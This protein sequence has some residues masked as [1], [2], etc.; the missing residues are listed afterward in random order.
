[1]NTGFCFL[2]CPEDLYSPASFCSDPDGVDIVLFR[3]LLREKAF[4]HMFFQKIDTARI[5]AFLSQKAV[6]II[7]LSHCGALLYIA[8]SPQPL[9]H[10][11]VRRGRDVGQFLNTVFICLLRSED[12]FRQTRIIRYFR[13]VGDPGGGFLGC[14]KRSVSLLAQ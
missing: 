3:G 1:M 2:F 10:K 7:F 6:G 13:D 5:A 9:H 8:D 14:G 4:V 11:I 12:S